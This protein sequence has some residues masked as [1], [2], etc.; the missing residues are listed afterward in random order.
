MLSR[1]VKSTDKG[2]YCTGSFRASLPVENGIG[3]APQ[4]LVMIDRNDRSLI[5]KLVMNSGLME[6]IFGNYE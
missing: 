1:L 5:T 3:V 4:H 6:L 2:F